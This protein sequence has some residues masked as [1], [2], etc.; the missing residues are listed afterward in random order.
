MVT[1]RQCLIGSAAACPSQAAEDAT[2]KLQQRVDRTA[3][4]GTLDLRGEHF[5]VGT[6]RLHSHMTL[7][8][9]RFTTLATD[10]PLT[11][12]V[13]ID[14]NAQPA[15]HITIRNVHVDGQRA[16]QRNL[17]SAEDGGRDGFRIVGRARRIRLED[18]SAKRC[19]TDGLKIFSDRCLSGDDRNLNFE[20]VSV[21]RCTFQ[22]NRRHGASADSVRAVRFEDC[23]F[24]DNGTDVPGSRGAIDDGMVYG[25]GIDV[26]GYGVGSGV[27]GLTLLR[28]G[29]L[30]NARFGIQFWEPTDPRRPGFM[31]RRNITI[32]DCEVD[33]G[34]SPQHGRQAVEFSQPIRNRSRG[35][36][37]TNIRMINLRLNGTLILHATENVLV[38]GGDLRS[39]YPG[40]WGIGQNCKGLRVEGAREYGKVF[41]HR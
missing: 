33:G 2:A 17:S 39:P 28:C 23:Q 1:R 14:G 24:L 7:A 6:I 36:V 19:A 13:T 25:A 9:A 38:K 12:P 5:T 34:V 15:E 8:N 27:D 22:E 20:D 16:G 35:P 32:E 37:Y 4:G 31:P 40:F 11:A 10:R 30:R 18:C 29:F 21:V 26:E 41:S 3:A